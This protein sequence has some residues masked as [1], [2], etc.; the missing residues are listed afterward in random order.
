VQFFEAPG[1][2]LGFFIIAS[3]IVIAVAGVCI[4]RWRVHYSILKIECVFCK[5]QDTASSVGK[6]E[7]WIMEPEKGVEKALL[8][9]GLT[10]CHREE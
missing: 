9:T 10:I 5:C 4:I 6:P 8:F 7:S 3:S 1:L 2:L